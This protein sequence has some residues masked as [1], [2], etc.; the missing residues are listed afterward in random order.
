MKKALL[1]MVMGL[2]SMSAFAEFKTSGCNSTQ[3]EDLEQMANYVSNN[4]NDFENYID[5]N[6]GIN[7]K[8]CIE[9]RFK[10]NGTIVCEDSCDPGV[11]GWAR[12]LSKKAHFCPSFLNRV[13]RFERKVNR[14]ACYFALAAHEFGHTCFRGHGTVE[15]IDD[16]A[17]EWY[18][19]THPRVTIDLIDCGM[20]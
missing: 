15:D 16:G 9:N 13:G 12:Y 3:R 8:N 4:W 20:D 14:R 11:N 7:L 19:L 1:V 17:F 18:E 5:R 6:Y 2:M 10:K